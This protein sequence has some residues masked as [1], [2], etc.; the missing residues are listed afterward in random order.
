MGLSRLS[1]QHEVPEQA[2]GLMDM[3]CQPSAEFKLEC[4]GSHALPS[5]K[6][7]AHA[8]SIW[9]PWGFPWDSNGKQQQDCIEFSGL[10][11]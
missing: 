6:P 11:L 7:G 9:A 4:G 1:L 5:R 10:G 3:G 8:P 2:G